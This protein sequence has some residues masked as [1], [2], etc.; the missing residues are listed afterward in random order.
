MRMCLVGGAAAAAGI[1][2]SS[3]RRKAESRRQ[4]SGDVVLAKN[5]AFSRQSTPRGGVVATNTTDGTRIAYRLDSEAEF[6]LSNVVDV[7][8]YHDGR[9]VSVS[10][11]LDLA[12]K[13]YADRSPSLVRKEAMAFLTDAVQ[14]CVIMAPGMYVMMLSPELSTGRD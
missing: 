9:R 3:G 1:T 8:Q 11:L 13:Q 10:H 6:M 7:Q 5:P 14:A 12:V 2:W 4:L